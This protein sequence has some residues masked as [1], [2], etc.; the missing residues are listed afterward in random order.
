VSPGLPGAAG[1]SRHLKSR[2][3]SFLKTRRG[4]IGNTAKT[5]C[6]S[7]NKVQAH[8]EHI[9]VLRGTAGFLAD[10]VRHAD[11][12]NRVA[13]L[14]YACPLWQAVADILQSKA[15]DSASLL[16]NAKQLRSFLSEDKA[17]I[18]RHLEQAH[19][20]LLAGW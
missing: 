9:C 6:S 16:R 19:K 13:C 17:Y 12:L 3:E 2:F 4:V 1:I 5:Y 14:T 10:N 11:I 7:V 20:S 8:P 15:G 18:D